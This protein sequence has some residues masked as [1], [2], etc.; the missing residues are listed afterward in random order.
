[1]SLFNQN[2]IKVRITS[3]LNNIIC[4]SEISVRKN[5]SILISFDQYSFNSSLGFSG[6]S[7]VKNPPANAEG[8]RDA[9]STP[10]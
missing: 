8:I 9:C 7:L 10:G 1:M 4:N 6:S 5:M 3:E 2:K